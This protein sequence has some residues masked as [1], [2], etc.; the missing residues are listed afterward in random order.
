MSQDKNPVFRKAII[1]WYDSTRT[2]WVL[3]GFLLAVVVFG[4]AGIDAALTSP[5]YASFVWVP[6]LLVIL[7]LG[8]TALILI[9]LLRRYLDRLSR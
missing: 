2:C 4:Q 3:V 6:L 8:V 5:A 1:P 9:R 7:G